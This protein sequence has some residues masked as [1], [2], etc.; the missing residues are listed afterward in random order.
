MTP[1]VTNRREGGLMPFRI[2]SR[3]I[4]KL[5]K[6]VH[7]SRAFTVQ[8]FRIIMSDLYVQSDRLNLY[9]HH[10]YYVWYVLLSEMEKIDG[11]PLMFFAVHFAKNFVH[12]RSKYFISGQKV[13]HV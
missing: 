1:Q 12:I 13:M 5:L 7:I 8:H 6:K 10:F 9:F 11:F 4:R 3:K 2:L